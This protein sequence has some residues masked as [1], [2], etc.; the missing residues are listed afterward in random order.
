MIFEILWDRGY[1]TTF[2]SSISKATLKL[3][4]FS[5]VDDC[6]LFNSAP[7]LD[8]TFTKMKESLRDWESLIEVTG[9]CVVLNKSSWYLGDY[10]WDKGNW[11]CTDPNEARFQLEAKL[12]D[13][14]MATLCRLRSSETM[15]MLRIYLS[16]SG[17]H[18]A[19][20]KA[21]HKITET[22]SDRI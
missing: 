20:I 15:E 4:G 10:V 1:G 6:D 5:Y 18:E 7:M 19:Q 17:N 22:W 16:T 12:Q 14:T 21:M 8:M 11:V 13:G 9:G 2:I 3:V